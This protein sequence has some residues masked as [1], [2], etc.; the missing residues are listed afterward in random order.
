MWLR[1]IL[2]SDTILPTPPL[3]PTEDA[4]IHTINDNSYPLPNWE[5]GIYYGDG[6]GGEF[7]SFPLIRRCGVGLCSID[8]NTSQITGMASLN[9]PGSI[10]T[11]PRS[12]YYAFY[13]LI[14]QATYGANLVFVTD[15]KPLF[16][17]FNKG[18]ECARLCVNYDLLVPV[19]AF[20]EQK[21]LQVIVRWMPSHL[22]SLG[23]EA[24]LTRQ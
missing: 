9:L 23:D 20:I 1:G 16:T 19:F 4:I 7:S 3:P 24:R 22:P 14:K 8:G 13:Y 11:V 17:V 5:S 2:P 6:S 18:I 10:Q 15:H 21:L 12:E